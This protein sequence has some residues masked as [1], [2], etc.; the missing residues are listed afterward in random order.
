MK[1]C[2]GDAK[3]SYSN[4]FAIVKYH[5]AEAAIQL[6]HRR[7]FYTIALYALQH[8][9]AT[10]YELTVLSPGIIYSRYYNNLQQSFE[11]LFDKTVLQETVARFTELF[12]L[13]H[14]L[15]P[16]SLVLSEEQYR[17][18][19]NNVTQI[20]EAFD[21]SKNDKPQ[22]AVYELLCFMERCQNILPAN[23]GASAS[24]NSVYEK[25][26][27]L[28][29]KFYVDEHYTDAYAQWLGIDKA[30]LYEICLS[31][32]QVLAQEK[33]NQRICAEA[34]IAL[35]HINFSCSQMSTILGYQNADTFKQLYEQYG[36]KSI[37][38]KLA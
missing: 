37:L 23:L 16:S 10:R 35:P 31:V 27:S 7:Q 25:F 12:S 34:D 29:D 13:F 32:T 2:G 33:I 36:K 19:Y 38:E 11:I 15:Q 26:I 18:L 3:L 5:A 30:R 22:L 8:G 20:D 1:S 24:D 6:P 17:M 21:I 9:D 14:I 4:S 28:L